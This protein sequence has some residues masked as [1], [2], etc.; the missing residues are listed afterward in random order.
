MPLETGTYIDSLNASNPASGDLKSEGDDHLRLIKSTIKSTFPNIS[1]AVTLTQTQLNGALVPDG[2]GNVTLVGQLV[3]PTVSN[4]L[5]GIVAADGTTSTVDT[6]KIIGNYGLTWKSMS[7]GGGSG[8]ANLSGYAGVSVWV[9]GTTEAMRITPSGVTFNL[10]LS[11]AIP[12]TS[13]TGKPSNISYFSNDS[14]Y[15]TTSGTVANLSGGSVN[16]TTIAASGAITGGG[17]V[18]ASGLLFGHSGS[19]GTGLGRITT[20]NVTGSPAGTN[21]GDMVL[22]Y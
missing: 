4:A 3:M 21:V 18:S 10:P 15:Q 14:G 1:G 11:A 2:S 13:V 9:N 19:G 22:V 20:T 17:N 16:A 7:W 12:W 8:V 5:S 6:N